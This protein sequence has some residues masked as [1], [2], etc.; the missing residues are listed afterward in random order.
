MFILVLYL[1]CF[2]L[3]YSLVFCYNLVIFQKFWTIHFIQSMRVDCSH[4]TFYIYWYLIPVNTLLSI[5]LHSLIHCFLWASIYDFSTIPHPGIELTTIRKPDI[6]L[7]QV[8]W[9]QTYGLRLHNYTSG[10]SK[11]QR[12]ESIICVAPCYLVVVSSRLGSGSTGQS[13][14]VVQHKTSDTEANRLESIN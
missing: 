2:H 9:V 3:L 1:K 5:H 12:A 10:L 13:Y 8:V 6:L 14:T 7:T 4:S 11:R